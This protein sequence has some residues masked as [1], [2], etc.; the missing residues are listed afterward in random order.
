MSLS[1]VHDVGLLF[2]LQ[3][4]RS[5]YCISK[6]VKICNNAQV[7]ICTFEHMVWL[8]ISKALSLSRPVDVMNDQERKSKSIIFIHFYQTT[9]RPSTTSDQL[10]Q[11]YHTSTVPP[12]PSRTPLPSS[13]WMTTN[14]GQRSYKLIGNKQIWLVLHEIRN[15]GLRPVLLHKK[16]I[17]P[18]S[19][20]RIFGVSLN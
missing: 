2:F 16:K 9:T 20:P 3:N 12:V 10:S 11:Y 14:L 6:T 5:S 4:W 19:A 8:R 13:S 17:V 1:A 7:L 18:Q 15:N